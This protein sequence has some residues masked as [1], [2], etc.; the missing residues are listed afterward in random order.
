VGDYWEN[1][2]ESAVLIVRMADLVIRNAISIECAC[3]L[4]ELSDLVTF[5]E[6]VYPRLIASSCYLS[7]FFLREFALR[8][9]C[10]SAWRV[11]GNLAMKIEYEKL[12]TE[13][14]T[15]SESWTWGISI[16]FNQ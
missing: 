3:P 9:P 12:N 11:W 8:V 6:S 7:C 15:A 13:A 5:H 1:D 16:T 4:S 14:T 10:P 2:R